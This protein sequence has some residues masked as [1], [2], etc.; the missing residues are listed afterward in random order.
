ML[1]QN[2]GSQREHGAAYREFS[3]KRYNELRAQNSRV[4]ESEL[5]SKIIKEWDNMTLNERNRYASNA[6]I[7]LNV[8]P[9]ATPSK[10]KNA[11][12]KKTTAEKKPHDK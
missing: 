4:R 9:L 6:M 7:P 3:R 5:V 2:R 8:E 10:D 11:T 1:S 12:N